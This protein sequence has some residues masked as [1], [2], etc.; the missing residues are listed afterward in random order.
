[1]EIIR[2][3]TPAVTSE[4]FDAEVVL[5]NFD[6]GRYHT[7]DGTGVEIWK[8]IGHALTLDDIL[9]AVAE[10]YDGVPAVIEQATRDF[11]LGLEAAALVRR[12][13]VTTAGTRPAAAAP[14][15]AFVAPVLTTFTDMQELLWLDPIHEV[16]DRG[17]PI[18]RIP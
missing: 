17:W 5:V 1:M 9:A 7:I 2:H 18:A 14:R 8:I 6:D 15:A 3:N 4:T 13:T 11:V 12:E 16:D 10:R